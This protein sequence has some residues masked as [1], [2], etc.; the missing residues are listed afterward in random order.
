M[1]RIKIIRIA[2]LP[3]GM[4]N[5][6]LIIS[7][8]GCILVDAGLPDSEHK[9]ERVLAR[10]GLA[11]DNIKLII[12]AHAH[13]DHAGSAARLRELSVALILAH[14]DDADFYSGR[15]P[16]TFCP[17][18]WFG[19]VFLKTPLPYQPYIG[20][21]PDILLGGTD[22]MNLATFG[23]DGIVRHT[24]RHTPGSISVDLSSQNALVGD[25]I[26]S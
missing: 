12:V 7:E 23:V 5:A 3:F 13:V 8:A 11:L 4:V 25:L 26:S 15:A 18:G 20:L 21:E 10:Y 2:I 19:R 24:A 17:T 9:I 1:P 14:R 6:H 16:M 22:T